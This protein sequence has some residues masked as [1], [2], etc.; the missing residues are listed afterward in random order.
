MYLVMLDEDDMD[1]MP[2]IPKSAPQAQ[3]FKVHTDA[4]D[5]EPPA[6]D[7]DEEDGEEEGEDEED[8]EESCE[9][10][11]EEEEEEEGGGSG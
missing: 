2:D 7:D 5:R 11:E 4:W 3:M 6:P 1:C 9:E 10:E 8:E